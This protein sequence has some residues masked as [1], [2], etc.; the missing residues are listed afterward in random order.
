MTDPRARFVEP[1]RRIDKL[2]VVPSADIRA[3]CEA[4]ADAE[5]CWRCD[6]TRPKA[7]QDKYKATLIA[8]VI[9]E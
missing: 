4:F 7:I 2:R 5:C 9:D 8:E 1:M 6:S 3:V